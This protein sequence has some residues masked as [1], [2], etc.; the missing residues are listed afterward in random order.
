MCWKY[1]TTEPPTLQIPRGQIWKSV[2][3]GDKEITGFRNGPQRQRICQV[4]PFY[5]AQAKDNFLNVTNSN[6]VEVEQ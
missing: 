3:D 2:R 4:R 5:K 6:Y 1:G